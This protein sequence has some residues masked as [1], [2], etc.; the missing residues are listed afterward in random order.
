MR[1]KLVVSAAPAV[2][3]RWSF[4]DRRHAAGA[5]VTHVYRKAG[6]YAITLVAT[7]AAVTP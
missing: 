1:G 4:G 6:R 7:D 2:S 5:S 3:L